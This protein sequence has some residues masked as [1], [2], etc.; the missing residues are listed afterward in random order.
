MRGS[1]EESVRLDRPVSGKWMA[2][3]GASQQCSQPRT[4]AHRLMPV[5][6]W[7]GVSATLDDPDVVRPW[8]TT[9]CPASRLS[10]AV[11]DMRGLS[12]NESGHA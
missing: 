8:L 10:R 3:R 6:K 1:G 9:S 12:G 2:G 5:V 7:G 4:P 11:N